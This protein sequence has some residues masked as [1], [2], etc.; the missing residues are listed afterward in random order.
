MN[1]LCSGPQSMGNKSQ[2]HAP[3]RL[4]TII[5]GRAEARVTLG[6]ALAALNHAWDRG[7]FPIKYALK[8]GP[9]NC[10][11]QPDGEATC[12]V[13][14]LTLY[15]QAEGTMA[16]TTIKG[17]A[18]VLHTYRAEHGRHF[19]VGSGIAEN[20]TNGHG[21]AWVAIHQWCR[22]PNLRQ[23]VEKQYALLGY[24][25]WEFDRT[26][27]MCHHHTSSS[28]QMNGAPACRPPMASSWSLWI[29]AAMISANI[30]ELIFVNWHMILSVMPH[31]IAYRSVH[32]NDMWCD[33]HLQPATITGIMKLA[34][35]PSKRGGKGN[36]LAIICLKY[37]RWTHINW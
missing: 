37:D 25:G 33:C 29:L 26:W 7:A 16:Q 27:S 12:T 22:E 8:F 15:F 18:F 5:D 23:F 11:L 32:I 28:C 2:Q 13:V 19:N 3:P 4:L 10:G 20:V 30:V 6:A 9:H 21:A 31:G 35:W 14:I 24:R 1:S 17:F 36:Y 34:I